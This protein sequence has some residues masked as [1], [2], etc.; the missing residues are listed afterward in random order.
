MSLLSKNRGGERPCFLTASK[1]TAGGGKNN[2][3][4][5]VRRLGSLIFITF[6][7]GVFQ[8]GAV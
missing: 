3:K 5:S 2:E 4:L 7:S 6:L 8:R 1:K